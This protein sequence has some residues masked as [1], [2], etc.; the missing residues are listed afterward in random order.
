[1]SPVHRV[2]SVLALSCLAS[3]LASSLACLP[4]IRKEASLS[5]TEPIPTTIVSVVVRVLPGDDEGVDLVGMMQ[6]SSLEQFGRDALP[7]V[8]MV[9][10]KHGFEP[11]LE[12]E[13]L[14]GLKSNSLLPDDAMTA[15]L[16]VWRH[17]DAPL[18]PAAGVASLL[19][20]QPPSWPFGDARS[21][22]WAGL[23]QGSALPMNA[24][25]V[26]VLVEP[27]T[28]VGCGGLNLWRHPEVYVR[29][30][31]INPQGQPIFIAR[32]S[33]QRHQ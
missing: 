3:C 21:D 28:D 33:Q 19:A 26:E 5:N 8:E 18:M 16:G 13:K 12:P 1:M 15:L 23:M 22:V 4:A 14:V 17:P 11:K 32:T 25:Y 30:L 9:L 29:A 20:G 24:T 27:R 31:T 6:N 2:R 7:K 10:R